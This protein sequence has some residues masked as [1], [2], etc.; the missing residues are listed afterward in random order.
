M[1]NQTFM[2]DSGFWGWLYKILTPIEWL[3]TWVM[4]IFHQFLML[5][6][7]P[8][9]GVSWVL[10]IIFLV[11]VV[12]ACVF[13]L[14]YKQM[15]SMRKMQ[16]IQPKMMRI[17]NKYKGKNDPASRDAMQRETMKLY[18]DNK[19]NP[20]GSCLPMLIQGP[21]FMCMFYVLSAIPYIA[22][23]QRHPLGAF[24]VETA[25]NFSAT[26]LFG[27]RVTDTF[28][29]AHGGAKAVIVVFVVLM[30]LCLWYMQFNMMKKNTAAAA[31]NK[32]TERMQ[33]M[34]LWIFPIMYIFSGV[35]MPFAVLIYWL[36]NNICNLIRS[37]WQIHEFPTPGSP[38][39]EAKE[40]RDYENENRRRAKA[41]RP[42]LEEEA[43]EKAHEESERK[44]SQGFQREQPKRKNRNKKK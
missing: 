30:C 27:T 12:Q 34:M 13:P 21:V 4:R 14:F 17:Q 29:T 19:V 8:A 3:M 31:S 37:E 28:V 22:R 33:K 9:V 11:I 20:A 42:S 15:K 10:S 6:G 7:M 35:A 18:Q 40:K 38:A 5:L 16:A 25:K 44:A 41:G 24:D 43:L 2:L 39:A 26:T 32:Q 36:A 23:G 1:N